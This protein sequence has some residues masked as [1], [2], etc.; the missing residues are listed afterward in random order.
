MGKKLKA[1]TTM[2]LTT[3][4]LTSAMIIVSFAAAGQNKTEAAT[5]A[6]ETAVIATT[7]ATIEYITVE[8]YTRALVDAIGLESSQENESSGYVTEL[9][10][11]GI[12]KEGDFTSYTKNLTRGDALVLLN[13]AEEYL[14][15][16]TTEASLVRIVIDKRI[17]DITNVTEAKREDIAEAYLK[18]F[19]KGYSNGEYCADR[20]LKLTS[21]I[22][23]TGALGSIK[24]LTNKKIRAKISPD[25]QLIRTTKLPKYAKYYPY[26]LASFPNE[27]YDQDFGYEN[28]YAAYDAKGNLYNEK[29]LVDYFYPIDINKIST[30]EY[31]GK[32]LEDKDIYLD[33]WVEKATTYA[34]HVFNVDYRSIDDTWKDEV[35]VA[36][37]YATVYSNFLTS[38]IDNY[39]KKMKEVK[40]IV[41]CSDVSIDSSSLFY[42][43][44]AFYLRARVR[45][46]IVSTTV[47]SMIDKAEYRTNPYSA[48]LFS[49]GKIDLRGFTMGKWVEGYFNICLSNTGNK[50]GLGVAAMEIRENK[51]GG[52]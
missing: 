50:D 23:K 38:G 34:N 21:K 29:N 18:G 43:S 17:S 7:E 4:V 46:Q 1:V 31:K 26:I 41:K 39:I 28:V 37:S 36:S 20:K 25:G 9:L 14:N 12:I 10:A 30:T 19:M 15:K 48:V 2:V 52:A 51:L 44:D 24:M 45:Y 16:D 49:V 35:L 13:R 6:T 27:Y 42:Y 47:P 22:T 33:I 5:T 32:F 8:E 40:T 11:N 3:I